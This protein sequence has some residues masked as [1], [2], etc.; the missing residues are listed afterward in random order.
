MEIDLQKVAKLARL[1]LSSDEANE[2]A[3]QIESIL[4][5]VKSIESVELS[6]VRIS[7][8]Q[9]SAGHL[10]KDQAGTEERVEASESLVELSPGSM[11]GYFEVPQVV[12]Q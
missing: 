12:S 10:R 2:F 8:F 1:R 5:H 6:S 11:N 3:P 7:K 9:R 4:E